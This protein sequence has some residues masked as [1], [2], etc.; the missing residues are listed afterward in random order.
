V[1]IHLI[2]NSTAF[3]LGI[4]AAI[5]FITF[6]LV[7]NQRY[8]QGSS[9]LISRL[10]MLAEVLCI[11]ILLGL[12]VA[13][14]VSEYIHWA[15][16]ALIAGQSLFFITIIKISNV[17]AAGRRW[18]RM[19]AVKKKAARNK[20][21]MGITVFVVCI[22]ILASLYEHPWHP[23]A[24]DLF[25]LK[26]ISTNIGIKLQ[27]KQLADRLQAL[28]TL[29]Q[30]LS[31]HHPQS[32]G[33]IEATAIYIRHHAPWPDNRQKQEAAPD[34]SPEI[35]A[36][37]LPADIQQALSMIKQFYDR[38]LF[39][40]GRLIDL[41]QSNLQHADL[42]SAYLPHA[43]LW[44]VNLHIALLEKAYLKDAD[45]QEARLSRIQA[46]DANFYRANLWKAD[47]QGAMLKKTHLVHVNLG[48]ANL[49]QA[50]LSGADLK[51]SNMQSADLQ[52]AILFQSNLSSVNLS[53]ARLVSA[54][55]KESEMQN[56]IL[57]HANLHQASLQGTDLTGA[58][59]TS[60][61]LTDTDL[62]NAN[63]DGAVLNGAN[64]KGADLREIHLRV[65]NALCETGSLYLSKL[66]D[67]IIR[68]VERKCPRL[69]RP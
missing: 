16:A 36:A 65:L 9:H 18:T 31:E 62:R 21:L 25:G 13:Y 50:N 33:I 60:A 42:R 5:G 55:L 37:A 15:W 20:K 68:F 17:R 29:E 56:A 8:R 44:K 40:N 19:G 26:T 48:M 23:T 6:L 53:R 64:L 47:L 61:L 38:D 22:L 30:M 14:W 10:Y 63:L 54:H 11:L 52:S 49:K 28:H 24:P 58:N 34:D 67:D 3:R 59:L 39:K 7:A 45:L 1:P 66:D 57:M 35:P 51:Q 69:L 32:A 27:S 41:N 12:P 2:I 43:K 46:T 4:I